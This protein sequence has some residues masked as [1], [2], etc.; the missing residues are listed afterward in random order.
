MHGFRREGNALLWEQN[1][2]IVRI[3][4][5]GI[6]SLRVRATAAERILDDL[7]GALLPPAPVTPEI[8]IAAGRAVIRN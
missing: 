5:W 8:D 3:E 7:P 6:D 4:P 2:A 1:H